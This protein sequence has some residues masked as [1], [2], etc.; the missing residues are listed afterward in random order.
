MADKPG[1]FENSQVVDYSGA[2]TNPAAPTGLRDAANQADHVARGAGRFAESVLGQYVQDEGLTAAARNWYTGANMGGVTNGWDTGFMSEMFKQYDEQQAKAAESQNPNDLYSWFDRSDAT[3]VALWDDE[4]RGVV[5]GDVYN[6]GKKV[7]NVYK[8]FDEATANVMMAEFVLDA[9]TKQKIFADNDRD[10]WLKDAVTE[11]ID[12][13]TESARTAVQGFEFAQDVEGRKQALQEGGADEAL[14]IGGGFGGGFAVGAGVGAVTGPGALVTGTAFGVIG[15]A[16]AYLNRDQIAE[17][18]ARALEISSMAN[19]QYGGFEANMVKLK[20][21]GGLGI[22]FISPVSNAIQGGYDAAAGR[23]GDGES[24]FYRM[25]ENGERKASGWIRGAD[26]AASIADGALQFG[27]RA[28]VTAYLGAT[29]ANVTGQ[30]GFMSATGAGFNDRT[31]SFDEYEG[32]KENAAAIGAVGID[33]V[34]MGFGAAI[35]KAGV[36]G[37]AAFGGSTTTTPGRVQQA[38][39]GAREKL[40]PWRNKD[41]VETQIVNGMR[42]GLDDAGKAIT[43]RPTWTL[44]AP[45]EAV[46]WVP[47]SWRARN[48]AAA[49]G[50]AATPDDYYQAMLESAGGNRVGAALINGWAESVEEGVQGLLEPVSFSAD[51]EPGQVLESMAY[52]MA[53]GI[54]MSLGRISAPPAKDDVARYRANLLHEMRNQGASLTDEQWANMTAD[55]RKLAAMADPEEAAAIGEAMRTMSEAQRIQL[56]QTSMVGTMAARDAATAAF[57]RDSAAANQNVDGVLVMGG[58]STDHVYAKAADGQLYV[59]SDLLQANSAVGSIWQTLNTITNQHRGLQT[60]T[61]DIERRL[62]AT[63]AELPQAEPDRA[64]ELTQLQAELTEQLEMAQRTAIMG[65]NIRRELSRLYQEYS[66]AARNQDVAGA[67]AAIDEFNGYIRDAI[68]GAIVDENGAPLQGVDVEAARRAVEVLYTRHPI[69]EGGSFSVLVP[70]ASK[71]LSRANVH[72][73]VMTHQ[74]ILKAMGADRDG[75]TTVTQHFVVPTQETLDNLRAGSQFISRTQADKVVGMDAQGQSIIESVEKIE[76]VVDPPDGEKF[77]VGWLKQGFDAPAGSVTFNAAASAR[78]ALKRDLH[79]RY[80]PHVDAD[81]LSRA[82]KDFGDQLED[83]NTDARVNLANAL[84]SGD[85]TGMLA[86]GKANRTSELPWL[87]QRISLEWNRYQQV[88]ASENTDNDFTPSMVDAPLPPD[89]AY[90]RS[91]AT[92]EGA[93]DGQTMSILTSGNAPVREGQ[94]YHYSVYRALVFAERNDG[95]LPDGFDDLIATYAQVGSDMSQSEQEAMQGRNAIQKRVVMWLDQI[96][97]AEKDSLRA[98]TPSE[99]R[100]LLANTM[101]RDINLTATGEYEISDGQ[102]SLLQLLLKRSIE[103]EK[104]QQRTTLQS[105]PD[106]Q[107]KIRR[108]ERLSR[109]EVDDKNRSTTAQLAFLEVFGSTPLFELLGDS[110]KYLGAQ[111]TPNQLLAQL[112]NRTDQSRSDQIYRWRRK[113]PYLMHWSTQNPPYSVQEVSSGN[114][115]SY[116]VL[117]DALAAATRTAPRERKSRD[118]AFQQDF[119][120]GIDALRTLLNSHR[121]QRGMKDTDPAVVLEDMLEQNPGYASTLAALIPDAAKLG[122]IRVVN[123]QAYVAQWVR[124]FLVMDPEQALLTYRVNSWIAEWNALG[125]R[126]DLD[127]DREVDSSLEGR[128]YSKIK[129]RMLQTFYHLATDATGYELDRLVLAMKNATSLDGLMEVIN[130]E[131]A[132]RGDRAE[133]LPFYDDVAD[134]EADPADVWNAALP[135]SVQREAIQNF[136]ART[137]MMSKTAVA[138]EQELETER[139]IISAIRGYL[140]TGTDRDSGRLYH[141][142]LKLAVENRRLF[143][144]HIGPAARDRLTR[145]IQQGVLRM[146][147]KGKADRN[148]AAFGEQ[149]VTVDEFGVKQ[150]VFQAIDSLT[151]YDGED[152]LTNPTKLTEGPVRVGLADGSTVTVDLSTVE[153]V[154]AA[155]ENPGTNTFAK[156][157]LFPT[158][159]DIGTTDNLQSW[160]DTRGPGLK[161]AL[162]HA[163]FSDVFRPAGERLTPA[164]AH[165]YISLIESGVRKA[166]IDKSAAEQERAF[167]PIQNIIN[168]FIVAYS[169]SN[170]QQ[171]DLDGLRAGLYV[172]VATALQNMAALHAQGGDLTSQVRDLL[173]EAMRARHSKDSSALR[174]LLDNNMQQAIDDVMVLDAHGSLFMRRAAE[175]QGLMSDPTNDLVALQAELDYLRKQIE[176]R[177]QRL[178]EL[179]STNVVESAINMFSITGDA[180]VDLPR[181]GAILRILG[182][183]NRKDRFQGPYA[184]LDRLNTVLAKDSYNLTNPDEFTD[185]EWAELGSFAST[186]YLAE[187]SGRAGSTVDLTP[188]ILGPEGEQQRR[189]FDPSFSYL[190][191]GFLNTQVLEVAK[192]MAQ[193]AGWPPAPPTPADVVGMFEGGLLSEKKIGQW[194]ELV[195]AKSLQ[196]RQVLSSASVGLAIP[197]GGE[198]PKEAAAYVGAGRPTF[199]LPE[200]GALTTRSKQVD[201]DG[202]IVWDADDSVRLNNHFAGAVNF[203][204]TD[205]QGQPVIVDLLPKV[206]RAWL[207]EETVAN[208]PYKI[209]SLDR[210]TKAIAEYLDDNPG[211]TALSVDV[212]YFDPETK[213]YGRAWANNVYYEG[214]GREGETQIAMGLVGSQV[215]G[216]NA[217][218]KQAQQEPLNQATKGGSGYKPTPIATLA[219]ATGLEQSGSVFEI[220]ARKAQHLQAKT[221]D[222]GKPHPGDLN[223]FLKLMKMR[224]VIVGEN[225]AGEKEVWWAE[226]AI[227]F[228]A[229]NPQAQ[230][231]TPDFPLANARLVPLTEAQSQTLLGE[232]GTKGLPG[233]VVEPVLNLEDM[234]VFPELTPERLAD[235]GLTRLG[236]TSTLEESIFAGLQPY[237]MLTWSSD[238]NRVGAQRYEAF[239]A[240]LKGKQAEVRYA[241]AGSQHTGFNPQRI[242]EENA[243]MLQRTLDQESLAPLFA[244][245]GIPMTDVRD[246]QELALTQR[247]TQK[248]LSL[249]EVDPSN[250]IWQHVQGGD[251]NPNVGVL[252]EVSTRNEFEKVP[253]YARPTLGDVVV[254]D[255]QSFV[256]TAGGNSVLAYDTAREVVRQY[257]KSGATIVLGGAANNEL[258]SDLAAHLAS[259]ADGYERM[260]E[261]P[262]F[263]APVHPD[264]TQSQVRRALESTLTA[265][266]VFTGQSLILSHVSDFYGDGSSENSSYWDLRPEQQVWRAEALTLLPTSMGDKYGMPVKSIG[267]L[268]QMATVRSKVLE[269]FATPEGRAH[270]KSLG[271]DPD[272]VPIYRNEGGVEEP[273]IRSLDD[274]IDNLVSILETGGYPVEVGRELMMGDLIPLLGTDGSI[275]FSRVG[276]QSPNATE[277]YEQT[278][279][280]VDPNDPVKVAGK[281][282]VAPAKLQSTW[283]V[284][285][286][287]VIQEL[288]PDPLAG[289]SVRVRYDLSRYGKGI[290]E[291]DGWKTLNMPMPNDLAFPDAALG[292]NGVRVNAATARKSRES[293]QAVEGQIQNWGWAFALT[294]IDFRQDMVE[295]FLG[296]KNRTADEMANDW[297]RVNTVLQRV[298]RMDHGFTASELADIFNSGGFLAMFGAELNAS[299]SEVFGAGFSVPGTNQPYA[300]RTPNERLGEVLLYSLMAPRVRVE[301]VISTS[302]LLTLDDPNGNKNIRLM[303][304]L[305]TD[306]LEDFDYPE[307]RKHLFDR[308]NA[309]M[310]VVNGVRPYVLNDDWT[311]DIQMQNPQT[312]RT[313]KVPGRL[314]I[315]LEYAADENPV[316]YVQS[317]VRSS[318]QGASQHVAFVTA[319]SIGARTAV[320]RTP[321][322]TA[323]FFSDEGMERFD[324]QDDGGFWQLMRAIPPGDKTWKPWSRATPMQRLHMQEAHIRK[325]AYN[326]L[327]DQDGWSADKVAEYRRLQDRILKLMVGDR[328]NDYRADVDYMVRQLFGIAGARPGQDPEIGKVS[329]DAAVQAASLILANVEQNLMPTAGGVV[330]LWDEAFAAAVFEENIGRRTPWAPKLGRNRKGEPVALAKEWDDWV[331]ASIGQMRE[332]EELMDSMFRTDLDGF[333]HTWQSAIE[334]TGT[335][336]VSTDQLIN[337][338]LMDRDT[339]L[340]VAS[341]DPKQESIL[342]SPV[343]FET[344]KATL[345]AI[346]GYDPNYI[347]RDARTTPSSELAKRIEKHSQWISTRKVP[348]QKKTSMREYL[349]EGAWYVE[350]SRDTHTFFHNLVNLSVGMRLLNPALWTSAVV[351][352]AVRNNIENLTNIAMG[353][354]TGRIGRVTNRTSR[355]DIDKMNKLAEVMGADN[356]FLAVIY[357]ELTYKN[358][359][360]TGRGR[361]GKGLESFAKFSARATSDPHFGMLAK[362]VAKRYLEAAWSYIEQTDNAI[363][364]DVFVA[365]MNRNP[366]WLRDNLAAGENAERFNPHRAGLNRVAQVRSMKQTVSGKAMMGAIDA[367]GSHHSWTVNATGHLLKIPFLFTR[368]NMNALTSLAGL[369]GFDQMAAMFLDQRPNRFIGRSKAFLSGREYSPE[370]DMMDMSDVLEGVDLIRPFVRGAVTH[371]GLMALAMLAG[372]LNLSGEDEETKRRRRLS[373]WMNTPYIYDPR[374]VEN[375]WLYADAAFLDWLPEWLPG[376]NM[377]QVSVDDEGNTRSAAQPHWMVRQFLSPVLGI[378]RFLNTGD[379]NQI[380]YGFG[381]AFAAI[382][383]SVSRLWQE[384]ELTADALLEEAKT[385]DG[386][387]TPEAQGNGTQLFIN[388]VGVYER[389]LLENS[390][391]NSVRSAM[392]EYNRNPWVIPDVNQYGEIKR[393]P[394]TGAPLPGNVQETIIDPETGEVTKKYGSRTDFDARL[395]QYAENNLT[396][397]TLLSLF[398]GQWDMDSSYFRKNM[399]PSQKTMYKPELMQEQGEAIIMAALEGM[400]RT[401]EGFANVTQYEIEETLKTQAEANGVWWKKSEISAQAAQILKT[402]FGGENNTGGGLSLIDK[403][404]AALLKSGNLDLVDPETGELSIVGSRGVLESLRTGLIKPGDPVMTGLSISVPM[405]KQLEEEWTEELI[406]DGLDL[407]LSEDAA[408][409]RARRIWYGNTYEDPNAQGLK[410][411]LWTEEIDWNTKVTYNQLNVTFMLG[412]DGR[413][414]ATPFTRGNLAQAL[415]IP[416]PSRAWQ[417][418]AGL[419]KDLRGNTVDE[420]YGLNTGLKGLERV[421]DNGVLPVP[422]DE[423]KAFSKKYAPTDGFVGGYK[424]KGSGWVNFGKRGYTP[425]RRR[426]YGGGGYSSGGYPN[427][428][429]MYGLPNVN[430]PYGNDIPFINT[431]NPILRR[432]NV[433]RE[434]VWSERGR[435]NQWQ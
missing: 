236:E 243:R 136:A 59:D 402:Q 256:Q 276:F 97:E 49:S 38:V 94:K 163:D 388:M 32:F 400:T 284:R 206:G 183:G 344:Q 25:D 346:V 317:A 84:F 66:D 135:G 130:S 140:R 208:S 100:L 352:V 376:S 314:Q 189:F 161:S 296:Q 57:V 65:A 5:R 111:L 28:G 165:K 288:N 115:S 220:L 332:S 123:G 312:G 336:A 347:A 116:R 370:M 179:A 56:G 196:A 262:H 197:V 131:P 53:G 374:R 304:A 261:S 190:V 395:H 34:Q 378:E 343:V 157:V 142:R 16:T 357:D 266:R 50:G 238:A 132:W 202:T 104:V 58:M 328:A 430:T 269:L 403:G 228:Q 286:P 428:E 74:S 149:L 205:A 195:P 73:Q 52:G 305:F 200:A 341:L 156:M 355:E 285:P 309:Q 333:W 387:L 316:N 98:S 137:K 381:D 166:A 92:E 406:Q 160:F 249:T 383:T 321:E 398:T 433:R 24:E 199:T 283:T 422:E 33:A 173:V 188:M 108:L 375:E 209:I 363:P 91:L 384:A 268:D 278:S 61:E 290:A 127:D 231:G 251:P 39:A 147:D 121:R 90:A 235:A 51:I 273:G 23:G 409:S 368:F 358:L 417:S 411:L 63:A 229:N 265:S 201:P 82:L 87:M 258:R 184:L 216:V 257:A 89:T 194:T 399:V 360:E 40:T 423:P 134:Y 180:G 369:G 118:A 394:N 129:S 282:A 167:F 175:I 367:M 361:I 117:V 120:D 30:I 232:P 345:D 125:A 259:G 217:I 114:L 230:L 420:A 301:D 274:A 193:Q 252:T 351:E 364:F 21:F 18:T 415:G 151:A 78:D 41:V 191:D 186:V 233:V 55:E 380:K 68:D 218:S 105:D 291:G 250:V 377:F 126:Q 241:R 71:A 418:R 255:L 35:A 389:A 8:D 182:T 308:V 348:K 113:A 404:S 19:R 226:Q 119:R 2:A 152:I 338:K 212:E 47:T 37:R 354:S 204:A 81:V 425:Y 315:S 211:S 48:R 103:I 391:V 88:Y 248:V 234:D 401:G 181:K 150:S 435:L 239:I 60:V 289:A 221:Y 275:Y 31:A 42:F 334:E 424:D 408:K 318:R 263:F 379:P 247:L 339:N 9:K 264:F 85:P 340:A 324:N 110:A 133:L 227:E 80:A 310:P 335:M 169:H 148:V 237:G 141:E 155:L 102:V 76:V 392:D 414:W 43:A 396:A 337:L 313:M 292:R 419:T 20:E 171:S 109:R 410:A 293:K 365:Q 10:R 172:D 95:F 271:G 279:R 287:G 412:P 303:P 320:E 254:L 267:S 198:L 362:S 372:G 298:S 223:S 177:I 245:L 12:Q 154:L 174:S 323:R 280:P 77:F 69:I 79:A 178:D 4:D 215:F 225:A 426:S 331:K 67:E 214:V 11:Q 99:A 431:S 112:T 322:Q 144:D 15:A 45:S 356:R 185:D 159:R 27:G 29:G 327:I 350:S 306:A 371:T 349:D 429:K 224:H 83:G 307:L 397:A 416:L 413:P 7:A 62:E 281:V 427:F 64:A 13:N 26:I 93:N 6:D 246:M 128:T 366:M 96:A 277:L 176:E 168:E 240:K 153:G 421:E 187:L 14:S 17:Q 242:S 146:H 393:D 3:G 106:L 46:R 319:E 139:S 222:I 143:P 299:V 170:I 124:E 294:G 325:V 295:Y 138:I 272:N 405:R 192:N 342:S 1:R 434:R 297:A 353:Q 207:A 270:I 158:V 145:A 253:T 44:L 300:Q 385:Q 162:D 213:P 244:R 390:F 386:L 311:F 432:A 86:T 210:I 302:G 164:Q 373:N 382:P 330:P 70:Q 329:A 260:A 54:G 75:D 107:R 101:V 122:A 219:T 359:V 326:Q 36:A 203:T 72:G 22:R 407:G